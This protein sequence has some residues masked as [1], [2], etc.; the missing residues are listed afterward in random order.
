[1]PRVI[2]PKVYSQ[3]NVSTIQPKSK[4]QRPRSNF[5]DGSPKDIKPFIKIKPHRPEECPGLQSLTCCDNLL[6]AH[7]RTNR[8][9]VLSDDR[10][11]VQV[12]RHEMGRNSNDFHAL[13]VG[14]TVRLRAGK[15]RKQ[16]GMDVD[17][18]VF[19]APDEVGREYLHEPRQYHEI[20]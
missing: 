14:L 4:A 9:A 15:T 1:M 6:E 13:L 20:H 2:R 11:L 16:R 19:I 17:D 12:H 18:L 10:T 5:T 7:A 8:E 3:R